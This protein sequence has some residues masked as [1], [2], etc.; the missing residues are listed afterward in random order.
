L[1]YFYPLVDVPKPD[2]SNSINQVM[3]Q[4]GHGKPYTGGTKESWA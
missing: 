1:A 3:I 4:E 2:H